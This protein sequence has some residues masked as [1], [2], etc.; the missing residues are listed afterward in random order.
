MD[1]ANLDSLFQSLV[2]Q[3]INH[4]FI[5]FTDNLFEPADRY[6]NRLKILE[7]YL[8]DYESYLL[9]ST[10]L[11]ELYL[12]NIDEPWGERLEQ[13]KSQY[14]ALKG[15]VGDRIK[16]MQNTNQNNDEVIGELL[17]YF[18]VLDINLGFYHSVKLEEYRA[19]YPDQLSEVWW[20]LNIWP[21]TRPNLFI[22]YPL[23][24]ARIIGPM[25]YKFDIQGFEYW[26]LFY[27]GGYENFEP[28]GKSNLMLDWRANSKS[29]DGNL[30]YPTEDMDVLS[31]LRLEALRDGF[32][33]LEY[34]MLLEGLIPDHP[35]LDVPIVENV[36]TFENSSTVYLDFRRQ[37]AEVVQ[38][39]L[40]QGSSTESDL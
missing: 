36:S 18:D 28:A 26:E 4:A 34:L 39:A 6:E 33:D 40:G 11:P 16:I 15:L 19:L 10:Q 9:S 5:G 1:R 32:E 3:S 14:Q 12:Y 8:K 22:E 2:R 7:S 25:S 38:S 17:G 30:I 35:L 31:S 24:D 23:I 37:V 13:A 29:L 21:S 20:N 27:E